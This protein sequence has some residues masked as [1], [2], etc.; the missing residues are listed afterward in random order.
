MSEAKE[1]T[2]PIEEEV[3][4]WQGE[5]LEPALKK[6]PEMKKRFETVSL[7]EV[8]R[9]YT[10]ADIAHVDFA[11]DISFP[12]EFPY[13]RGIHPTGYRGLPAL[14]DGDGYRRD[15]KNNWPRPRG[16]RLDEAR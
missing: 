2:T 4:R 3:E 8:E 5:T 1:I 6:H 12:G 13:T 15:T 7:E 16:T 9:L 10:P 14:P 11:R